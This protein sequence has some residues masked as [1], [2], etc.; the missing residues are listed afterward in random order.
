MPNPERHPSRLQRA[1][2]RPGS[3]T[4][5]KRLRRN[6]G[7]HPFAVLGDPVRRR[8]VEALAAGEHSSGEL[9]DTVGSEFGIT[10][11][12]VSQQLKILRDYGFVRVRADGRRRIYSLDPAPIMTLDAWIT[13]YRQF[14]EDALDDLGS[15]I[16][17]GRRERRKGPP[18]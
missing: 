11:S 16:E 14:W 6:K 9:V 2:K 13:H 18:S 1:R 10:Q 4:P 3:S 7:M 5:E 12:A 17:Q 8:I 15:E